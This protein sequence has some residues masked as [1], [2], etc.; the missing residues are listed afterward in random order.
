MSLTP[1][2]IK[3]LVLAWRCIDPTK[4]DFGKLAHE[5]NITNNASAANAYRNAF[6]K[7]SEG[8]TFPAVS[9][10]TASGK[11][12]TD[13]TTGVAPKATPSSVKKP[14][15]T[16]AKAKT[17]SNAVIAAG[18]DTSDAEMGNI[19]ENDNGAEAD[20]DTP[21]STA[22]PAAN[23]AKKRTRKAPAAPELDA[24][25]NP[26]TPAAKRARVQKAPQLDADGRPISTPKGGRKPKVDGDG[27]PIKPAPRVRKP[28]EQL[29]ENGN[30]KPVR[31]RKAPVPKL[32][33]NGVEIPVNKGGR[34]SKA[35]IAAEAKEKADMEALIDR[36]EADEQQEDEDLSTT[37]LSVF[38]G[39]AVEQEED[40]DEGATV[41]KEETEDT[42]VVKQEAGTG[43]SEDE[44]M[45]GEM[46]AQVAAQ[47]QSD[48]GEDV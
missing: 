6:K 43:G 44:E 2:D 16:P 21:I 45:L 10:L 23:A 13:P 9:I 26:I 28:K 30:V 18:A 19:S 40:E 27:N 1:V 5:A 14:R 25:G 31:A 24:E 41:V 15:A 34:K 8:A 17:K 3:Y 35:Q 7:L 11:K 29:D 47:R 36:T 4:V 33:D 12:A 38:G 22:T 46:D 48:E 20:V 39:H 42:I 32:D 37:V